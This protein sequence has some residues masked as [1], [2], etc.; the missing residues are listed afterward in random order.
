MTDAVESSGATQ[1]NAL[2]DKTIGQVLAALE[3][4]FPGISASKIRFLEDKGLV[5]PHRTNTGYRKYSFDDVEQLR[6]ILRLQR[7]RY[8]PLKVIKE[9]IEAGDAA[10][11]FQRSVASRASDPSEDT[12]QTEAIPD[13]LQQ[14]RRAL[15]LRELSREAAADLPLLRE[16]IN[17]GLL[18]EAGPY[19]DHDII[20]TRVCSALTAHGLHP[21]HLRQFR[22]AVDREM[23]LVEMAVGPLASRKDKESQQRARERAQEISRL[24][25][26]LHTALVASSLPQY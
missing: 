1:P 14:P 19:D 15:S 25:L 5:H 9:R 12:Q 2:K 4:E 11:L 21:R 16:L 10:S 17:F 7:D 26:Q 18:S 8:L 20:I 23:G 22:V 13:L 3:L 24:C 6:L